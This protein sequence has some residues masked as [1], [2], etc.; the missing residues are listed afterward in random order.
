MNWRNRSVTKLPSVL[1]NTGIT[2][3]VSH[4]KKKIRAFIESKFRFSSAMNLSF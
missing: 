2:G 3:V 1:L 4:V